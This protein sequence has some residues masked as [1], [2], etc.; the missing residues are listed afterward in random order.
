MYCVIAY[1]QANHHTTYHLLIATV[2]INRKNNRM[3]IAIR[4]YFYCI[5]QFNLIQPNA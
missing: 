1:V 3:A 5:E 4:L 2:V